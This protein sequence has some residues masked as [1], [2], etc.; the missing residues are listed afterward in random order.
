MCVEG[1][2]VM[3]GWGWFGGDWGVIGDWFGGDLGLVWGWLGVVYS[4]KV[5]GGVSNE[6]HRPGRS[7]AAAGPPLCWR[8]H[9]HLVDR[10]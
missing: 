4:V 6:L 10:V 8:T 9:T 5:S 7:K 3:G 1:G 2:G